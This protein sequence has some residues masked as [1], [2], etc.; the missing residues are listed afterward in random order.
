MYSE[1]QSHS[2]H[3]NVMS[4]VEKLLCIPPYTAS[5]VLDTIG[6]QQIPIIIVNF[7]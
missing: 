3:K 2:L 5:K 7:S 4:Q 1:Q 6:Q